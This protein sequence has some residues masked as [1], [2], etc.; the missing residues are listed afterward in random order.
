MTAIVRLV[1]VSVATLVGRCWVCS[2]V[3]RLTASTAQRRREVASVGSVQKLGVRAVQDRNCR[4]VVGRMCRRGLALVERPLR[5]V[6]EVIVRLGWR[7]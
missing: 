6:L 1:G 5:S 4:A 3:D 2:A 7:D